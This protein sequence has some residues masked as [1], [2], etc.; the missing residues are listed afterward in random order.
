[1]CVC[2]DL[3]KKLRKSEIIFLERL[4]LMFLN[5]SIFLTF[6]L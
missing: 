4:M 1:M 2:V 5:H 6:S 3:K